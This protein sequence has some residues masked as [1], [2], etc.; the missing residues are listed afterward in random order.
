MAHKEQREFCFGVKKIY[1]EFFKN[2]KVL[3]IGSLDIN[4]CNRDLFENCQYTGIDVGKGKNVDIISVGHLFDGEDNY[5]DTIISTEVFEHDMFYE[6]TIINVMRMLKPG[7]LFL[8][9]CAA[10]GRPEHGT[11]RCGEQNAP[12]LQQVSE[13]WADYYK[14]LTDDDI[15][16]IPN[17]NETFPDCYFEIKNTNIEIP[18][19]LY[20]YGIK[21]GDKNFNLK[22]KVEPK[23]NNF[24]N[25][26]FVIDSWPNTPEKE[27]TLVE[28]INK[29]KV[30]NIPII[31]CGHYPIKP[32]IQNMVDYFIFDKN[33]DV[34]YEK[35]FEK[36]GIN[37]DRWTETNT[38]KLTN[39][40]DF[41]HD[42]AIWLTMKNAFNL[43][44]QLGKKYI[45]FLE[46]DNLP[47]ETQ[48]RQSFLEY[49]QNQVGYDA[50]IQE[51]DE[52]STKLNNPYSATY[53]FSIKTN[54]A[55]NVI[56]QINS[57][58]EYF[59]QPNGWQLEKV[60]YQSL[61]KITNN[62][63]ISKYIPN[64][65]EL[66]IFAAWNRDGIFKDG[67][68]IQTYL[69]VDVDNNLYVHFIPQI[70]GKNAKENY[71]IEVEYDSNSNFYTINK[72]NYH[73]EKIGEYK[74][75]KT[76]NVYHKGILIYSQYLNEEKDEFRRKNFLMWKN[77][78]INPTININF[79]DGAFV[80]IIDNV[81]R[82]YR[83]QFINNKNNEI[84]FEST[85]KSTQ[86]GTWGRTSK[87][88]FIDYTIKI[89]GVNNDFYYEHRINPTNRRV[90]ICI[91]SK[92][93][94]DT[95]AWIPYI[96]KFQQT[97]GAKVICSSFHNKI[98]KKQYSAIEFVEPGVIV[99]D[100]YALYRIGLFYNDKRE[101]D[102][103]YHPFDPKKLPL[104]KLASDILGLDYV[105]IK[106][107]LQQF[108][109]KKY[110]QVSIA[111]HSTSQCKYWN[112]PN[113][114]QDV[115][116]YLNGIGY[117]VRLLSVEED[118][119]MGNYQP[120]NIKKLLKGDLRE[121]IRELQ[122]SE[123][124]IG[125]SSGLSWLSWATGIPTIIISGFTDIDLE[126]INGINRVIN[127][128]VC[129]GCWSNY[130]F[131]PG[132]W[133]WC[134]IQKGTERQFECSKM[135]TSE[136]VINEIKLIMNI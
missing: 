86:K 125:I 74:H 40:I 13:E 4:G 29:I 26:V 6:K 60:F 123:M 114:W 41:H 10:P 3:D 59:N 99:N 62:I 45:H 9:T 77:E 25:D 106:P 43:A 34:L 70:G 101:I 58:E 133:N 83:V 72:N 92:S 48:Y 131:N 42:Y 68:N 54:V 28:L 33:N 11:R 56:N 124:F 21:G 32:E 113:G 49:I 38:Y 69:G 82:D 100:I 115:V 85:L 35:D 107:R 22:K 109:R 105:E 2:K 73:L 96:E 90:L 30:F 20:F 136:Q 122:E 88:Y 17:F 57:K 129:N 15:K 78:T 108:G 81:E 7:G 127:K 120:K 44:N 110:K 18:S 53:I 104:Q 126:P 75:G 128:D 50:I 80:E 95:I 64:E 1:P 67:V 5:Y 52:G 46:Y 36:Y 65:N 63:L 119:F 97:T 103:M 31:L 37:S 39:K 91:E 87:K 19:D 76:I 14:N 121:V 111:I 27:D 66:N 134:P 8:F 61:K 94:G 93:I 12:L 55:L 116:D 135:I 84:D 47:D 102:F 132:D 51:Y 112:N 98:F 23:F 117:E 24:N 71:L 89:F 130:E 16:V 118:G 79:I